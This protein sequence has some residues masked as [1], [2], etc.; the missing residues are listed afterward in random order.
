[1]TEHIAHHSCK[2]SMIPLPAPKSAPGLAPIPW[3]EAAPYKGMGFRTVDSHVKPVKY[4]V[5]E[6]S[7][8]GEVVK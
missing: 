4:D 1:M 5:T 3:D 8:N 7:V 6:Y 2:G